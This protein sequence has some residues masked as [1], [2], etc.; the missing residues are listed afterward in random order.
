MSGRVVPGGSPLLFGV[1]IAACIGA[2]A[3]VAAG[4]P[5]AVRM[6]TVLALFAVA[7]GLALVALLGGREARPHVGLV[8]GLSL[9]VSVL[10]AQACL[11]L[12]IWDPEVAT[13][14]LAGLSLAGIV[15]GAAPRRRGAEQEQP[16]VTAR[17]S[18]TTPRLRAAPEPARVRVA[19]TAGSTGPRRAHGDAAR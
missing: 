14:A 19:S 6:A 13:Y 11:V 9:A 8:V 17:D 16:A 7:P 3:A 15:A 1:A 2:P 4:A 5:D 10:V 12:G 18:G